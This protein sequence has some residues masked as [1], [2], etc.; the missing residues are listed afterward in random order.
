[1][2]VSTKHLPLIKF[3]AGSWR[4]VT[5]MGSSFHPGQCASFGLIVSLSVPHRS[6]QLL[7]NQSADGSFLFRSQNFRLAQEIAIK[8]QCYVCFHS[9]QLRAARITPFYVLKPEQSNLIRIS[10]LWLQN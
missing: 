7:S 6:L 4:C 1:M 10:R 3:I 8:L 2:L 5:Q 9:T